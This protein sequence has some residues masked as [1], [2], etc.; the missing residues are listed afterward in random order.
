MVSDHAVICEA[1]GAYLPNEVSR[2][3]RWLQ[4]CKSAAPSVLHH[5]PIANNHRIYIKP[6]VVSRGGFAAMV[7]IYGKILA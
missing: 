3:R 5:F 1:E 7:G 4:G 2:H 6:M